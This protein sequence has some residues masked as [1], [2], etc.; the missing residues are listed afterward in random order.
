[1]ASL[2]KRISIYWDEG[3]SFPVPELV[4]RVDEW[5]FEKGI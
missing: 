1:M 3:L 5:S 4:T 2:W